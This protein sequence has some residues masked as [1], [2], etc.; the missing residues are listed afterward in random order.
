MRG[1]LRQEGQRISRHYYDLHCLQN[2]AVGGAALGD[3]DLAANCVRHA[4]LFFNRPDFDLASAQPGSWAIEANAGMV[5]ALRGD[6]EKTTAMIFG[7]APSFEA[8]LASIKTLNDAANQGRGRDEH[9]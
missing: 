9:C 7:A 5:D 8:I 6:Y 2:S 3:R 4:R 1:E